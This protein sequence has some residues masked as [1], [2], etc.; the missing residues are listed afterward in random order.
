VKINTRKRKPL[1]L[2]TS[3][4]ASIVAFDEAVVR[5]VVDDD[6]DDDDDDDE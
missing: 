4:I 5:N 1:K 3:I 2:Q 6:D